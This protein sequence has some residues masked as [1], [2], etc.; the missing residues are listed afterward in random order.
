MIRILLLFM[1]LTAAFF[2]N[3]NGYK[4]QV[5]DQIAIMLPGEVSLNQEFQI[6]RQDAS[7]CQKWA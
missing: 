5:G 2:V 3:A 1:T 6:D 4:V 7:P